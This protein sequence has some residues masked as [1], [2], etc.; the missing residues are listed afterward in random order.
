MESKRL[1]V[2]AKNYDLVNMKKV[3]E[4]KIKKLNEQINKLK[5]EKEK[6]DKQISRKDQA[7]EQL[8]SYVEDVNSNDF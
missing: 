4:S 5:T 7:K 8:L 3:N 1:K 2:Q 6:Y